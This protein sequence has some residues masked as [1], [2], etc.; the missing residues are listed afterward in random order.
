MQTFFYQSPTG[1]TFNNQWVTSLNEKHNNT[2]IPFVTDLTPYREVLSDKC[3]DFEINYDLVFLKELR[4]EKNYIRLLYSGGSDSD[5]ILQTCLAHDIFIDEVVVNT[6]NL[7]NKPQLQLC[8]MEIVDSVIPKLSRVSNNQVGQVVYMNYDA[9]FLRNLYSKK[10]WM[11]DI[12]GG[13]IAFRNVQPFKLMDDTRSDCQLIGKE[14]PHLIFY[15]N[16]WYATVID[17]VLNDYIGLNNYCYFHLEPRNIKSFVKTAKKFRNW[18][19][20]N[21]LVKHVNPAFYWPYTENSSGDQ[22]NSMS[23]AGK[24]EAVTLNGVSLPGFINRKDKEAIKEVIEMG[25]LDLILKWTNSI[26]YL[27]ELFPELRNNK[28]IS[29]NLPSKFLWFIDLDTLEIFSQP[30]LLPNGFQH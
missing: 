5:G 14:K 24:L 17:H 26:N 29:R 27:L 18:I 6:R 20:D 3:I 13:D 7:Y 16:H 10:D 22:F 9:E 12:P 4:K 2:F 1:K 28:N 15:N 11:F 23:S 8:D 30:E 21:K 25:D 19:I